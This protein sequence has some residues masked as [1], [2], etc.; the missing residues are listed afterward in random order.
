MKGRGCIPFGTNLMSS[1]HVIGR[2]AYLLRLLK[3]MFIDSRGASPQR[4]CFWLSRKAGLAST[5]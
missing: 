3:P 2:L 5:R 1:H 4:S